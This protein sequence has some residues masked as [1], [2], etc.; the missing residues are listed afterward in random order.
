LS[1]IIAS[2]NAE[3]PG[4]GKFIAEQRHEETLRYA[5]AQGARRADGTYDRA[6][7]LEIIKAYRD[8][9]PQMFAGTDITRRPKDQQILAALESTTRPKALTDLARLSLPDKLHAYAMWRASD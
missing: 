1:H 2:T 8:A 9:N 7:A 4:G 6:K 3:K 5:V